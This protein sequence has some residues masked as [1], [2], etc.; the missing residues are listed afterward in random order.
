[1]KL[2]KQSAIMGFQEKIEEKRRAS[3][4][5]ERRVFNTLIR[6]M[7]ELGVSEKKILKKYSNRLTKEE[8]RNIIVIGLDDF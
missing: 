4:M 7:I 6:D 8:L 2:N 5:I 1:M 3:E